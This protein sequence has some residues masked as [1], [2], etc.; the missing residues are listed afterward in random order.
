[1]FDFKIEEPTSSLAERSVV[2]VI[3]PFVSLMIGQVARW[4]EEVINMRTAI[5]LNSLSYSC[6]V[7]FRVM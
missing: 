2:L 4:A 6:C 3:S 5:L 7:D 1:M